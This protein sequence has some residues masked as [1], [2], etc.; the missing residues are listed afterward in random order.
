MEN[1]DFNATEINKPSGRP[2]EQRGGKDDRRHGS[3]PLAMKIN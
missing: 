1:S 3:V 2:T